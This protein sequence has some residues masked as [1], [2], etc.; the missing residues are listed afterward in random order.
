LS[1]DYGTSH[2]Q[3]QNINDSADPNK[4]YKTPPSGAGGLTYYPDGSLKSDA[5]KGITNIVY[6][7]LGLAE[8]IELTAGRSIEY[9]FDAEGLK[10]RKTLKET[11]KP[12][13]VVDYMGELLYH[14]GNLVSIDTDEGRA[15][16]LD[17]TNTAFTYQ[18]FYNDHLGNLRLAYG[19][20]PNGAYITQEN[21]YGPT[22]ELLEGI[23]SPQTPD[24]GFPYNFLFQGKE[25]E[26]AWGLDFDDFH[27]RQY[28]AYT[29]RM[30][31]IDGAHQ[32]ASGYV[33]MGNNAINGV[34]PDGQWLHIL[35]GALINVGIGIATGEVKDWKDAASYAV[36][37][38][39]SAA[40][41]GFAAKGALKAIGWAANSLKGGALAGAVGG[42]FGGGANSAGN[43]SHQLLRYGKGSWQGVGQAAL[44]GAILGAGSGAVIG[45]GLGYYFGKNPAAAIKL[46]NFIDRVEGGAE[47]SIKRLLGIELKGSIV[48]EVELSANQPSGDGWDLDYSD[49]SRY[50]PVTD[51]DKVIREMGNEYISVFHK[52]NLTGGVSSSHELSTGLDRASVNAIRGGKLWEFQ[53]PKTEFNQWQ[54]Q[55]LIRS[56]QDLDFATGIY[57]KELRFSPKL[58]PRLNQLIIR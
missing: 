20:A 36:I 15:T 2:N 31:Q 30:W 56:V 48:A 6:N 9:F 27:S 41:G 1:Y 40:F 24:G 3:L 38:G 14:N 44:N 47:R 57:N 18:F 19:I 49:K 51:Y 17:S 33:G 26:F 8:K 55:G 34:D 46:G 13:F 53:I 5:N 11:G 22:G 37:G 16:P 29:T 28:D 21:H 58:A 23:N 35:A 54:N 25:H 32:F 50:L 7:Y 39:V 42:F 52:G 43:A 10:L 45:G 4:G 12:D